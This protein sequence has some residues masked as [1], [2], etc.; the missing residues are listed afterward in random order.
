MSVNP[1]AQLTVAGPTVGMGANF[2]QTWTGENAEERAYKSERVSMAF[3]TDQGKLTWTWTIKRLEDGTPYHARKVKDTYLP[4]LSD[5]ALTSS[6]LEVQGTWSF[7]KDTTG[8]IE[9]EAY[10]GQTLCYDAAVE[11]PFWRGGG[12]ELKTCKIFSHL[13]VEGELTRILI[14]L[15][16]PADAARAE[17]ATLPGWES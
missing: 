12:L 11:R 13:P 3:Q 5:F 8:P 10:V 7:S 15:D 16:L 1:S 6:L 2:G 9:L 17:G 14:S 4:I